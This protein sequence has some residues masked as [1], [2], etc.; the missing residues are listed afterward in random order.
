MEAIFVY[1]VAQAILFL[2]PVWRI[3]SKAGFTPA[4]ALLVLIPYIG[5]LIAMAVLAL[6][7][8]PRHRGMGSAQTGES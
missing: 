5:P 7:E 1:I 8:W 2:I 4:A 6:A 3:F